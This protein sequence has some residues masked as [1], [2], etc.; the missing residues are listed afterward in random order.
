MGIVIAKGVFTHPGQLGLAHC[1]LGAQS[2]IPRQQS[3]SSHW[4]NPVW[5][6]TNTSVSRAMSER[7]EKLRQYEL[8]SE[9]YL[10]Q[11]TPVAN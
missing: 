6:H 10:D 1:I 5:L 4:Y 9:W 2:S 3:S 11:N 8:N 7:N